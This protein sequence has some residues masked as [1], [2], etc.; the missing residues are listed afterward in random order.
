M[1]GTPLSR[2]AS[3]SHKPGA[4]ERQ[5]PGVGLDY[6][7]FWLAANADALLE[8][9]LQPNRLSVLLQEVGESLVGE[10]LK[11]LA[12]RAGDGA[13]RLPR[14]VIELHAL[15][16]HGEAVISLDGERWFRP[17]LSQ[18]YPVRPIICLAKIGAR[19]IACLRTVRQ[20]LLLFRQAAAFRLTF[21]PGCDANLLFRANASLVW[22]DAFSFALSFS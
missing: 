22:S 9:S 10:L 1:I 20:E 15:A 14:L 18:S 17:P 5:G 7:A 21:E 4:H 12:L 2:R 8:C 13:D 11:A 16:G 19:Q 3:S 6:L